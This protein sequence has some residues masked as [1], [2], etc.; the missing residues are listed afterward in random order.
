MALATAH[1]DDLLRAAQPWRG[2]LVCREASRR[3]V[4]LASWLKAQLRHPTP[5]AGVPNAPRAAWNTR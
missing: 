5:P 2:T 1:R 4:R 3:R